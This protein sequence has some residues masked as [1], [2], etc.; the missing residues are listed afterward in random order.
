MLQGLTGIFLQY[1][2]DAVRYGG[3][4]VYDIRQGA[5][6]DLWYR[7]KRGLGQFEVEFHSPPPCGCSTHATTADSA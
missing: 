3:G 1:A 4:A 6:D 7:T 5:A 2:M